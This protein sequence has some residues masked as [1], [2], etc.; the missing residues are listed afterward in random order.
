MKIKSRVLIIGAGIFGTT[1]A[2]E[3]K[4]RNIECILVE[5]N[6]DIFTGASGNNTG[7]VHLGYH[8]PRDMETALQSFQNAKKFSERFKE[9]ILEKVPNNYFIVKDE[10]N[11][12]RSSEFEDFCKI[13][14]LPLRRLT[15][16]EVENTGVK[17]NKVEVGFQTWEELCDLSILSA[18]IKNEIKEYMIPVFFGHN[19]KSILQVD[20]LY[21]ASS[22]KATFIAEKVVVC[23]YMQSVGEWKFSE[24][25][26]EKT[27]VP[28]I[29]VKLPKMGNTLLDGPFCSVLP[30]GHDKDL[31]SVYSVLYSRIYNDF[32][33]KYHTDK[34][35]DHVS[36]YFN[37]IS[38]GKIVR[39][40]KSQRTIEESTNMSAKRISD[41]IKLDKSGNMFLIK[42]GKLDHVI[43]ISQRISDQIENGI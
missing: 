40:L 28:I 21:E 17:L 13:V 27:L 9:A 14:G 31:F 8:Y 30:F 12:T 6:E 2:I 34:I 10:K 7:R 33:I 23:T 15:L 36:Q 1:I 41:I 38:K 43:S 11:H 37:N 35:I 20:R 24:F 42:A 29:N 32:D 5:K 22:E 18:L 3:L 4:K 19:I 25:N 16:G 26:Y 39:V